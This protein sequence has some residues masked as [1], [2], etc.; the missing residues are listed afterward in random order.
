MTKQGEKET[1]YRQLALELR[2][3]RAEYKIYVIPVVKGALG[4]GIK[5]AIHEVK[6]IFKQDDLSG[7]IVGEMQRTIL[8]DG[9]T[10]IRKILSGLVQTE[11]L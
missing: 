1:K 3:R 5:E 6:K 4:G 9:E 10:V 11:F 8:M 7:K 2:E